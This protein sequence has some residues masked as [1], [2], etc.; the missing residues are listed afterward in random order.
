MVLIKKKLSPFGNIISVYHPGV[1]KEIRL[2]FMNEG[3]IIEYVLPK[4][5]TSGKFLPFFTTLADLALENLHSDLLDRT[6]IG[7]YERKTNKFIQIN[8]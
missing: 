4:Q 8:L 7:E 2:T 6:A 3:E 1:K 5:K